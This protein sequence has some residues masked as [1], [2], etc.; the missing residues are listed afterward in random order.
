MDN[1]DFKGQFST[2]LVATLKS[3]KTVRINNTY[4]LH[5]KKLFTNKGA[6]HRHLNPGKYHPMFDNTGGIWAFRSGTVVYHP[7]DSWG[8]EERERLREEGR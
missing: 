5:T 4:P 2:I 8:D 1:L 6:C 7:V 3:D